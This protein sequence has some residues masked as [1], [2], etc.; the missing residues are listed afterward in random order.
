MLDWLVLGPSYA[1][2]P[3]LNHF[4]TLSISA[5]HKKNIVIQ[6]W[7]LAKAPLKCGFLWR[8]TMMRSS[9]DGNQLGFFN[10]RYRSVLGIKNICKLVCVMA[11]SVLQAFIS[12]P[13]PPLLPWSGNKPGES[14]LNFSSHYLQAH[15][16]IF[17]WSVP[18]A[19]LTTS[20]PSPSPPPPPRVVRTHSW[21]HYLQAQSFTPPPLPVVRTHSWSHYLQAQCFTPP[22]VVRTHSWSHYLQAQCFTPPPPRGPYPQLVS[23]SP[24]P[25]LH[26]PPPGWS[27][28]TAG[29]T[30][31]RPSPSPPPGGPY[32]QLVSLPPGPVL[33][34]PPGGPYP[35]LVSLSPGV[36]LHPPPLPHTHTSLSFSPSAPGG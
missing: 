7:S 8:N 11:V 23:L 6:L 18:T 5:F 22:P 32:P 24:G 36:V 2:G 17:L 20:R 21:S 19:G 29:L 27:V 26:P 34:P 10:N 25:V 13:P 3:S 31:S 1:R 9:Y 16:I 14:I 15:P 35:Q 12:I 28:S 33:H 30:I 4:C